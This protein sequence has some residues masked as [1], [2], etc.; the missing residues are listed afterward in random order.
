[1]D[2]SFDFTDLFVLDLANNHQG[3][4]KHATNLIRRHADAVKKSNI[5]AAIK[6]QFRQLDSFVHP[7][8]KSDSNNKP[9]L[10]AHES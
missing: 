7:A 3:D 9:I 6:F 1:M 5:R 4:V 2:Q 8:H 10:N